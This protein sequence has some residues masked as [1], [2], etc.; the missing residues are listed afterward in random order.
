[1]ELF[2]GNPKIYSCRNDRLYRSRTNRHYWRVRHFYFIYGK[3]AET[4]PDLKSKVNQAPEKFDFPDD[5]IDHI[6]VFQSKF[7]RYLTDLRRVRSEIETSIEERHVA[8][9]NNLFASS[10]LDEKS[11]QRFKN[12]NICKSLKD[13]SVRPLVDRI[14]AVTMGVAVD[15][16][17]LSNMKACLE[18]FVG[19]TFKK[20][21]SAIETADFFIDLIPYFFG[22]GLKIYK[23]IKYVLSLWKK[24]FKK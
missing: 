20:N 9:I 17:D 19:T 2:Y 11:C 3:S 12:D 16:R 23:A 13:E 4:L 6:D 14:Y 15:Y 22:I 5:L 7:K 8:T 21:E 1:L 10:Q 24:Y 18:R